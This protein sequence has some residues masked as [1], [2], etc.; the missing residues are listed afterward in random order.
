MTSYKNSESAP[1]IMTG[2]PPAR[3]QLV[4]PLDWDRPPWNRWA[5]QRMSQVL[6]TAPVYRAR[7]DD[8]NNPLS[9]NK[10]SIEDLSFERVDG[11]TTTL[12]KHLDDTY[13]DAMLIM[14]KGAVIHES[15]YNDMQIHSLHLGQS[16]TKS[17]VA[18]TASVLQHEGLLDFAAPVTDYLPE[19]GKTAWEGASVQQ[20]MDMS[21]GVK[22]LETYD[23]R[24]SD[25]GKM[26]VACGWKPL[27]PDID[28][29][30]WP[31][32]VWAQLFTLTDKDADHGTRFHYRSV[33]T[34]VL[35]FILERVTGQRLPHIISEKLWQPLGAEEDA[36]LTIDKLGCS[37]AS[38][39]FSACLRDYA[40]FGKMLLDGGLVGERR[41]VPQSWI[42]D[43]RFSERGRFS[44]LDKDGGGKDVFPNGA[45][46]NQFW[47]EDEKRE[48]HVCLGVFGQVIYIAPEF[49]LVAVKLSTWPE[50]INRTHHHNTLRSFRAIADAL[51]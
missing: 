31:E 7:T 24:D 13:T 2:S 41:I 16:V 5:F 15:Y 17:I 19:L 8:L 1:P 10:Q 30:E 26:D 44:D 51:S 20:V 42:E 9:Y 37:T 14:H 47:I 6:P 45:Y 40:R 27:P 3:E 38:G 25:I 4:P 12:A 43:I 23:I 22:F 32:S 28:T 33:E 39:G 49:E 21:T 11:E 35:S 50:F 36:N 29:S 48:T 34:E 18:T 46:R